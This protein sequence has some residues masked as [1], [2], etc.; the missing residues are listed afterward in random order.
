LEVV[1]PG[2]ITF[3]STMQSHES[4]K[5]LIHKHWEL[6]RGSRLLPIVN[7]SDFEGDFDD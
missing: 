1:E 4:A 2:R 7:F 6:H 5:A 3:L